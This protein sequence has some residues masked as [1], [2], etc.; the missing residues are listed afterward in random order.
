MGAS[1]LIREKPLKGSVI[2][3]G[4]IRLTVSIVAS[5]DRREDLVIESNVRSRVPQ[6][7]EGRRRGM[8]RRRPASASA[9]APGRWT[10]SRP[11]GLTGE[12]GAAGDEAVFTMAVE[13]P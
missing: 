3:A 4:S 1:S 10:P 5:R 6:G 9:A 8:D 2:S 11:T 12:G 7:K 13:S